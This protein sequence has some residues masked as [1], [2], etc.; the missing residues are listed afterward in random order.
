MPAHA[1]AV[2]LGSGLRKGAAFNIQ[3]TPILAASNVTHKYKF[4][5]LDYLNMRFGVIL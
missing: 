4:I 3:T 1:K 2:L 5:L